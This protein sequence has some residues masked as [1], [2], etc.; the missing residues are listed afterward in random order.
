M[1]KSINTT[2]FT[3]KQTKIDN[4]LNNHPNFHLLSATTRLPKE[5]IPEVITNLTS[6]LINPHILYILPPNSDS[7]IV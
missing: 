7:K 5:L 2:A 1:Q 4:K 3:E 6:K